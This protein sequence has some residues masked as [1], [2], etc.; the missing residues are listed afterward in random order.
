M[1][2]KSRNPPARTPAPPRGPLTR[3]RI[4]QAA[5]ALIDEEGL[6]NCSMRRLGARL[7]VEAMALYHHFPGKAQLLD[8]VMDQLLDEID[9]PPRGEQPPLVRLRRALTSWRG[10]AIRH[11]RAYLLLAA[12]RFNTERAF[13]L[14]EGL[15]EAYADLGLDARETAY[16]FRLMGNFA[17]GSGMAEVAS[18]ERNPDATQLVLEHAPE[19]VAFPHVRAVA[20]HLRVEVLDSAF[21]FGMDVL[22][23]ELEERVKARSGPR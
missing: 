5:L 21:A 4:A 22:F 13:V 6:E 2:R 8:G 1:P 12:R 18:R 23:G 16:W 19:S 3:E 9:L 10:A 14:Y 11:P 7:G 20:P 15:L 17:S